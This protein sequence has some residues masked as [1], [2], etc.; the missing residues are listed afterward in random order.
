MFGAQ[1]FACS[2]MM[3]AYDTPRVNIL[4][5]VA[6]YVWCAGCHVAAIVDD[7]YDMCTMKTQ[8]S[9]QVTDRSLCMCSLTCVLELVYTLVKLVL[10]I[11]CVHM[12]IAARVCIHHKWL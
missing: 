5:T 9:Q 10:T 4:A 7:D 3:G 11:I 8:C 12:S 1:P 6:V 2:A